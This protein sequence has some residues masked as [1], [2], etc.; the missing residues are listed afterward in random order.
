MTLSPTV[1]NV[2]GDLAAIPG[3]EGLRCESN[4]WEKGRRE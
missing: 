2:V 4:V 3:D 1:A